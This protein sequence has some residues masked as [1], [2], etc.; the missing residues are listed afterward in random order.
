[1]DIRADG[2]QKLARH[3]LHGAAVD[4]ARPKIGV[5]R[6]YRGEHRDAVIVGGHASFASQAQRFLPGPA[7]AS[8]SA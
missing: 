5:G 2:P 7:P 3:A 1:M 8:S 4:A 6:L